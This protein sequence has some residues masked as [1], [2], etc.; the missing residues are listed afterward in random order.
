MT[1]SENDAKRLWDTYHLPSQKRTHCQLV[2]KVAVFIAERLQSSD[3]TIVI[4]EDLLYVA[5][6]LHDIDKNARKDG[7]THPEAAV[8]ILRE[9]GMDDVANLV[10][11]HSVH[12]ILDDATTPRSWEEKLLFLADKM[13][14]YEVITVDKRF[15]LWN[16]EELP[17]SAH[18]MLKKAYP[19]VKA[20]EQAIFAKIGMTPA[21]VAQHI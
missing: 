6:L 13:V 7:E 16:N 9:E 2:A 10:K 12:F 19:K 5:G 20:L 1:P 18:E 21:Q 14:K 15:A 17:Q 3:P 4:N 8:R 11:H